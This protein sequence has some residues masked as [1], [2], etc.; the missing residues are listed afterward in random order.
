MAEIKDQGLLNMTDPRTASLLEKSCVQSMG[1]FS[2]EETEEIEETATD[3]FPR[4]KTW[5]D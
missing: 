3:S 5:R 4:K 2:K 1:L